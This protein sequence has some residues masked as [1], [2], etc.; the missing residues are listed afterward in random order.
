MNNDQILRDL[1]KHASEFNLPVLDNA[2]VEFAAARLSAFRDSRA[3]L[4]VFEILGF[5]T[6]EVEFVDDLYA[7]GSCVSSEGFIGAEVP[8][9]PDSEQPIFDANTRE[10][11]ADWSQWSI[12]KDGDRLS[13]SP[14]I[15][16]YGEAG[17][18]IQGPP[19]PGTLREIELLR[20]LVHRL[21]E[22]LFL[23]DEALLGHF[24]TCKGLVKFVQTT[25]WQH[26]D[27]ADDEKPSEKISMRSLIEALAKNDSSIFEPGRSNTD[28]KFWEQTT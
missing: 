4:I 25:R 6:K 23:D 24:P 8:V 17:I 11:L 13:F 9:I 26:P 3:W 1:D 10:C 19:G 18:A 21:G 14:T 5:S 27:V 15:E 20:F 7:Y 12:V 22:H 28:W 16:E 2:Y